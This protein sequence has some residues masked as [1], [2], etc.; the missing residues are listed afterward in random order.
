MIFIFDILKTKN[1]YINAELRTQIKRE[2][3]ANK[4]KSFIIT[5]KNKIKKKFDKV[6]K[7]M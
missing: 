7:T 5:F 2:S 4:K 1:V 6:T 3:F